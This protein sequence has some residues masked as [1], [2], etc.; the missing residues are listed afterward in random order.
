[1]VYTASFSAGSKDLRGKVT[2]TLTPICN[3]K[4]GKSVKMTVFVDGTS[5]SG[6]DPDKSDYDGDGKANKDK[7]KPGK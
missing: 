7:A 4:P 1:M 5:K 2:I 3:G 6:F